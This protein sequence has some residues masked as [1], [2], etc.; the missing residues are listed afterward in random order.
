MPSITIRAQFAET[1]TVD[2]LF[3][4]S[5][6]LFPGEQMIHADQ[7][8]YVLELDDERSKYLLDMLAMVPDLRGFEPFKGWRQHQEDQ[9]P[10]R[11][12]SAVQLSDEAFEAMVA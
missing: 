3:Q 9:I 12:G 11:F 10:L 5:R 7:T 6:D 4:L 2:Q 1:E 8:G